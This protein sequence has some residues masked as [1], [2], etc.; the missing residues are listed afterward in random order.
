MGPLI[1]DSLGFVMKIV[2]DFDLIAIVFI[3]HTLSF[4]PHLTKQHHQCRPEKLTKV[5]FKVIKQMRWSKMAQE[6]SFKLL[7][8][9]WCCL[10][11]HLSTLLNLINK[12]AGFSGKM[13]MMSTRVTKLL[14]A[15]NCFSFLTPLFW[16][17][18]W[19]M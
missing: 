8:D 6:A 17:V 15:M 13:K 10:Y 14:P 11:N 5:C 7:A 16:K 1:F 3:L 4:Y 19:E 12:T 2:D 9:D 18:W